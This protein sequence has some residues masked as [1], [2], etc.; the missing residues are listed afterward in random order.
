M[1][2]RDRKRLVDCDGRLIAAVARILDEMAAAGT[3]MM[4]TDGAR[5]VSQQ[6]ILWWKGREKETG[7]IIYPRQVVTH[8]D[9]IRKKSNHQSGRAADCA[10]VVNDKPSWDEALPWAEYG[11]AAKRQGLAWGGD[12]PAPK[13]DRPHVEC[14]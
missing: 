1:T 11:A 3:P 7:R 8:C 5:T 9:G 10:F 6:Q 4:V 13:T 12:W 14:V 2:E